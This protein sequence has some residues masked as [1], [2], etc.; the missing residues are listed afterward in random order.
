MGFLTQK[1]TLVQST[2][3][4]CLTYFG[5]R[6]PLLLRVPPLNPS[7][8]SVRCLG[9]IPDSDTAPGLLP[10]L[11][12]SWPFPFIPPASSSH[13]PFPGWLQW[14]LLH[15]LATI[16]SAPSHSSLVARVIFSRWNFILWLMGFWLR[17]LALIMHCASL[18]GGVL[19]TTYS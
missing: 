15:V 13:H 18:G 5:S 19:D 3:S 10:I 14:P 11:S 2:T 12:R 4:L 6:N 16:L 8:G 7:S 9:Y 1:W 17:Y